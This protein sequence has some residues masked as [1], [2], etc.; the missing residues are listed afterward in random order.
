MYK[1]IFKDGLFR[2]TRPWNGRSKERLQR[3]IL[4]SRETE[5]L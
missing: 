2:N 4:I 5:F 1:D 3:V